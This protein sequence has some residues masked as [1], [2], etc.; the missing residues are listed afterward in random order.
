MVLFMIQYEISYEVQK[1]F[2]Q[3]D[4][5]STD[6]VFSKYQKDNIFINKLLSKQIYRLTDS[7]NYI[8][9][10]CFPSILGST[11]ATEIYVKN[12]NI[13]DIGNIIDIEKD[14]NHNKLNISTFNR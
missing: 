4:V 10:N 8:V 2:L 3:L 6:R 1:Y 12:G 13:N 11:D 9:E 7:T 5:S 14:L